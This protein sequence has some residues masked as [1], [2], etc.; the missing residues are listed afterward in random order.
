M[1][2][3]PPMSEDEADEEMTNDMSK[4]TPTVSVQ[5]SVQIMCI[6][7]IVACKVVIFCFV[8]PLGRTPS[9]IIIVRA[10]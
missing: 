1:L 2:N 4:S 10:K 6:I 9:G 7:I 5:Y 8:F 3:D